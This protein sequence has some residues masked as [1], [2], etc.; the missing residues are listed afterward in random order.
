MNDFEQQYLPE[1]YRPLS[2]WTYF[3]LSILYA[4][5]VI[6]WVFLIAHAVASRNINKRNY[7]RSFFCVYIL[8]AVDFA[9]EFRGL[10]ARSVAVRRTDVKNNAITENA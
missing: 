8:A 6:G 2:P 9:P 7:A 1:A 4:V 10:A 5:P 3:G